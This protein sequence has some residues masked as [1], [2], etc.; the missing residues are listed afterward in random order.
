M[1]IITWRKGGKKRERMCLAEDKARRII[2]S[3]NRVSV[4]GYTM[5]A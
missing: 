4:E 2:E 3:M 5:K 1:Q